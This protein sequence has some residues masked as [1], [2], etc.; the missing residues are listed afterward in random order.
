MHRTGAGLSHQP[1][2]SAAEGR[3]GLREGAGLRGAAAGARLSLRSWPAGSCS[4]RD[5]L[6]ETPSC[7]SQACEVSSGQPCI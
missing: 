3:P 5:S 6:S 4:G 7:R 1:R 2:V